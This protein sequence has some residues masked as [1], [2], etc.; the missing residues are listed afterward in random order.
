MLSGYYDA[1]LPKGDT[2]YAKDIFEKCISVKI[3]GK[4]RYVD[5]NDLKRIEQAKAELIV[6]QTS[7]LPA[8]EQQFLYKY[9]NY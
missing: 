8:F 3:D 1:Q 9:L 6:S 2:L 7:L 4:N 5:I